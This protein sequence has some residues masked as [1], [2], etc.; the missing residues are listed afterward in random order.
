MC[1]LAFFMT[2]G[3]GCTALRSRCLQESRPAPAPNHAGEAW[4]YQDDELRLLTESR[5]HSVLAVQYAD[6]TANGP[7]AGLWRDLVEDYLRLASYELNAAALMTA[8]AV[9]HGQLAHGAQP[10]RKREDSP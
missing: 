4:Q 2:V 1:S 7:D 5:R 6:K 3:S 8:I 10:P 9:T